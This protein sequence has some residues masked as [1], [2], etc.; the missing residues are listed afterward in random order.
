VLAYRS[1]M[2][3]VVRQCSIYGLGL[4]AEFVHRLLTHFERLRECSEAGYAGAGCKERL[5]EIALTFD[6]PPSAFH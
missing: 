5:A 1:D 3:V 6:D 4:T 2:L